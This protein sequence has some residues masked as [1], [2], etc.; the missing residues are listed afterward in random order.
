LHRSWQQI[1]AKLSNALTVEGLKYETL[2]L[3]VDCGAEA[4]SSHVTGHGVTGSVAGVLIMHLVLEFNKCKTVLR[5]NAKSWDLPT[6]PGWD[7]S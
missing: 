4:E 3:N 2:T 7:S 1:S 5:Y 6:L